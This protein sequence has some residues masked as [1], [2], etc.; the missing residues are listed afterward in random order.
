M[1]NTFIAIVKINQSQES[2]QIRMEKMVCRKVKGCKSDKKE[3]N[4]N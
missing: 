1:F 2:I 3:K 4:I